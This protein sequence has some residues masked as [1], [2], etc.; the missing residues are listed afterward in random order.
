VSITG[1]K[2][3]DWCSWGAIVETVR[4]LVGRR[5]D[6]DWA[7]VLGPEQGAG[8]L[9]LATIRAHIAPDKRI[10]WRVISTAEASEWTNK[11]G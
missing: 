10:Q 5:T 1:P 8:G 7:V 4:A 6:G 2:P 3:G 9:H 11:D